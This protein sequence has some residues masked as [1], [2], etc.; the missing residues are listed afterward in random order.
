MITVR[1]N[2][3]HAS[4][5]PNSAEKTLTPPA[6]GTFPGQGAEGEGLGV[7]GLGLGTWDFRV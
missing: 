4:Q 6:G 1:T 3:T 5:G 7:E 2:E